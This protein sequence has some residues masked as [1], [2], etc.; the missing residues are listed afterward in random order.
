MKIFKYPYLIEL[1][2]KEFKIDYYGN[3]YDNLTHF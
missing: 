3:I 1:I 2:Q